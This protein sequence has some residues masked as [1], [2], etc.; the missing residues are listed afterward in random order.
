KSK[1]LLLKIHLRIKIILNQIEYLKK[2]KNNKDYF[3]NIN[4][5]QIMFLIM[6]K[7]IKKSKAMPTHN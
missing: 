7:L 3:Y 2:F 1:L 4:L 5:N 6:I